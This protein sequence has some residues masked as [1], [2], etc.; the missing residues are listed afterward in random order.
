MNLLLLVALVSIPLILLGIPS[1]KKPAP[2]VRSKMIGYKTPADYYLDAP[3][4]YG[5]FEK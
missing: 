5:V 4:V 2:T 3:S 1:Q